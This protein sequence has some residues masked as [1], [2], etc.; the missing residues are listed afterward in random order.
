MSFN[1]LLWDFMHHRHVGG[2]HDGPQI[3][4]TG[5][6][7]NSGVGTG[8]GA[9]QSIAHK[10]GKVPKTIIL[11]EEIGGGALPFQTKAA[12]STYIYVQAVN[13]K[14]YTWKVEG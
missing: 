6:L 13:T 3:K 9:E 14:K 8:N 4:A 1:D 2:A 5:I 11:C 12:T 7:Q 10:L